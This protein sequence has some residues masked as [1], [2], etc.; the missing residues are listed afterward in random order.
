MAGAA[1]AQPQVDVAFGVGGVKAPSAF[2]VS[3]TNFDNSPQSVGG[4][5]FLTLSGD[6][7]FAKRLGVEMDASFRANQ[8]LYQAFGNQQPFRPFFYNFN[9]IWAPTL[10]KRAEA[11]FLGGVGLQNT[12][13]YTSNFTCSAFGCKNFVS[14][15]HFLIDGGAGLKLYVKGNIFIRPEVRYNFVRNNLEFSGPTALRYGVSLG[16]TL[17]SVK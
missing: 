5:T 8:N 7:I 3:S 6:F 9:A 10:G 17:R 1:Y 11:E 16:Y 4:G 15:K 12:R 14:S 2:D 13:F